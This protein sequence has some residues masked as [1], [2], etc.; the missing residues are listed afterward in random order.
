MST[1]T[2]MIATLALLLL[3]DLLVIEFYS[4]DTPVQSAHTLRKRV[5]ARLDYLLYLPPNYKSQAAWPMILF[6]HGVS[7][8]GSDV[9]QVKRTGL[10]SLIEKGQSFPFIIVSPQCPAGDAWVWKLEALSAL[11][12][13]VASQYKVDPDRIYVT[14][15][16]MGGFGSW[17]LAAYSPERFAAIVP[18]CGGGEVTSMPRLKRLPVWAFHGAKDDVVPVERTQQLVDALAQLHGDVKCTIYPELK[19]DSWT[20]TYDNPEL[21]KWLLEQR[22]APTE[23][24]GE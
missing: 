23:T 8:R 4:G 18:I 11:I 17:A 22:R 6:L 15:L 20:A 3:G 16:S 2:V 19:H 13:E 14:G 1:R 7:D 9:E 10:P 5:D 24:K 21:Y 12:D